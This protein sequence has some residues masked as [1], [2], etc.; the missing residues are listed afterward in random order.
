MSIAHERKTQNHCK[1]NACSLTSH[2]I[3]ETQKCQLRQYEIYE[4]QAFFS[5]ALLQIRLLVS[6]VL[7]LLNEVPEQD[8]CCY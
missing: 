3:R 7:T 2:C 4:N 5:C 1:H 8:Y 6:L